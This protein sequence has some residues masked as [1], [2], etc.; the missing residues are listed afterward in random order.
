MQQTTKQA[1][2]NNLHMKFQNKLS[3]D[4]GFDFS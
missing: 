3:M 1:H 4:V 2:N